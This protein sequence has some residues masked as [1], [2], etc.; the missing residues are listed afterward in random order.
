VAVSRDQV[1][2]SIREI[3]RTDLKFSGIDIGEDLE[4]VS[5]GLGLDS[6]DLLMLVTGIEK[7]FGHKIPQKKLNRDT[8]GTVG[9][10]ADFAFAEL[11]SAGK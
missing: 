9:R 2:E 3:I 6:L 7:R 4:L 1:L 8:M 11:S 5:G 10:F